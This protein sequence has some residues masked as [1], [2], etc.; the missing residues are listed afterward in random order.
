MH[1]AWD[2]TSAQT[3]PSTT[4]YLRLTFPWCSSFLPF[5]VHNMRQPLYEVKSQH[6]CFL[7][8]HLLLFTLREHYFIN[9]LWI[10][11]SNTRIF[12]SKVVWR[13][14]LVVVAWLIAY[15]AVT[16]P[17]ALCGT[18]ATWWRCSARAG[19]EV[20]DQVPL[21]TY[22]AIPLL[23]QIFGCLNEKSITGW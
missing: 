9:P 7:R 1:S 22:T 19:I 2:L 5:L 6:T 15:G 20:V 11:R 10:S 14:K 12:V 8:N 17:R 16:K 23:I 21:P 13:C 3:F 4:Y 18:A